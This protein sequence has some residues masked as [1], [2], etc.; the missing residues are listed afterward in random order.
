VVP[1]PVLDVAK[2]RAV[3]DEVAEFIRDRPIAV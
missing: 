2:V 1:V 3:A